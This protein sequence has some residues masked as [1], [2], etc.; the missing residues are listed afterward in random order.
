MSPGCV[1]A[2]AG[3]CCAFAVVLAGGG[4]CC[5]WSAVVLMCVSMA[6]TASSAIC[7][8][9]PVADI[10]TSLVDVGQ[11]LFECK[12]DP[13]RHGTIVVP[14]G[15]AVCAGTSKASAGQEAKRLACAICI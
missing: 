12:M 14:G 13:G 6:L 2:C 10:N 4:T 3:A 15:A 11:T 5:T 9:I 1:G 8:S 7:V